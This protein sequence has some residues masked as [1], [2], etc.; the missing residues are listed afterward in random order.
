MKHFN[1]QMASV[2]LFLGASCAL[3]AADEAPAVT[4]DASPAVAV[5]PLPSLTKIQILNNRT[6]LVHPA[7]LLKFPQ[8]FD[9]KATAE[10]LQA[11]ATTNKLSFASV[12][13]QF[14]ILAP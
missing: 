10:D 2:L 4:V 12:G 7:V 3:F 9:D 14:M 1:L 6:L 11:W 5:D 13:A 8:P